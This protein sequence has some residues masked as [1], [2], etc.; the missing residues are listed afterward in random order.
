MKVWRRWAVLDDG[1]FVNPL[2]FSTEKHARKW[3]T[4]DR[5]AVVR[6]TITQDMPKKRKKVRRG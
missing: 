5:R 6:V 2:V 4:T 1:E 3:V